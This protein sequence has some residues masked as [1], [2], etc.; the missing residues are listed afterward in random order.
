MSSL[1]I[2]KSLRVP[3]V[4]SQSAVRYAFN[5]LPWHE[6]GAPPTAFTSNKVQRC[7]R[8][9]TPTPKNAAECIQGPKGGLCENPVMVE[10]IKIGPHFMGAHTSIQT[11]PQAIHFANMHWSHE[12]DRSRV[13]PRYMRIVD[14]GA[15]R[16]GPCGRTLDTGNLDVFMTRDGLTPARPLP[17]EDLINEGQLIGGSC[18]NS[19]S[20]AMR[21]GSRG[22]AVL[23]Q[24]ATRNQKY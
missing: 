2:R 13:R 24:I 14:G 16:E 5:D 6:G 18:G 23:R 21:V 22:P 8:K 15:I 3:R 1:G 10:S 9:C 20:C 12:M 11:A 19:R 4:D 17:K 7:I